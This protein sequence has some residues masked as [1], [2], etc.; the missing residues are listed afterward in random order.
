MSRSLTATRN[1]SFGTW[2]PTSV[3]G[4]ERLIQSREATIIADSRDRERRRLRHGGL[5]AL[6]GDP[7]PPLS[8]A[9]CLLHLSADAGDVAHPLH[10]LLDFGELLD[11]RAHVAWH[12]A[13]AVGD[14]VAARTVDEARVGPL[15]RRHRADDRLDAVELTLVDLLVLHLLREPRDHPDEAAERAHLADLLELLEEV[16]QRELALEHPGRGFFG[17]F[18]LV[19]LLGLL[20]QRE[21]V[22]HA[23]DATRQPVGVELIEVGELLACRREGDGPADD[24]L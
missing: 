6:G 2:G 11:Q 5:R 12:H 10:H 21:H 7:S 3:V 8:L 4:G 1:T 16:L 13:A 9:F 20:D 17:R 23:E 18:L 24:L 22:A 15:S 19:A 14:A